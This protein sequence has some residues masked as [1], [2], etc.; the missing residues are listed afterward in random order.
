MRKLISAKRVMNGSKGMLYLDGEYVAG[1]VAFNAKVAWNK[2]T[3]YL[4]GTIMEDQKTISGKGTGSM[5][6]EKISSFMLQKVGEKVRNGEDVRFTMR[7][8]LNDPDAY[9]AERV[10]IQNVS[11]DEV[12]IANWGKG[13][14]VTSTYPYTFSN[15]K[16]IDVVED[17]EE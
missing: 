13:K 3:V 16:L 11:F 1:V 7:S 8:E 12:E 17:G 14:K 10:E 9:G 4:D 15:W 2:E 6:L 5:E